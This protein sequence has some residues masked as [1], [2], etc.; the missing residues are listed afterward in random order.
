MGCKE[1]T[2]VDENGK[3]LRAERSERLRSLGG[4]G[5]LMNEAGIDSE[6]TEGVREGDDVADID[7]KDER[8][9]AILCVCSMSSS[10][11]RGEEED[12]RAFSNHA[13]MARS[14]TSFLSTASAKP[15]GE[16]SPLSVSLTDSRSSASPS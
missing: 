7:S 1:R 16:K 10:A 9:L 14:F 8:R 4:L 2:A 5:A 13:K 15:A 12:A 3:F 6:G 11:T